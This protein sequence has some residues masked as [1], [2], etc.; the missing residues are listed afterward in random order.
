M[1]A[2]MAWKLL[3]KHRKQISYTCLENHGKS[4][5]FHQPCL[6]KLDHAPMFLRLQQRKHMPCLVVRAL[7]SCHSNSCHG[8]LKGNSVYNCLMCSKY[9]QKPRKFKEFRVADKVSIFLFTG[10][11]GIAHHFVHKESKPL[12]LAVG[13]WVV[14]PTESHIFYTWQ[15]TQK[16]AAMKNYVASKY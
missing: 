1:F 8:S 2:T 13:C 4:L 14:Q 6:R 10:I 3:S 16:T 9:A 5:V 11:A 7:R 12:W 15:Q